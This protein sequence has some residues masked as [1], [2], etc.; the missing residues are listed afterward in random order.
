MDM[1]RVLPKDCMCKILSLTTPKDACRSSAVCLAL[2]NSADSDETWE[3]FLP[4]ELEH[5]VAQSSSTNLNSL[6][7][8]QLYLHLCDHPL[9]LAGNT[10]SFSLDKESGKKCYMIGARGLWILWSHVPKYWSYASIQ[11]SRFPEVAVLHQVWWFEVKGNFNTKLLSQ[12]TTYDVLFV[13]QFGSE[14]LGFADTSINFSLNESGIH[15]SEGQVAL[16]PPIIGVKQRK[17]GWL[18]I[19]VGEFYTED[20]EDGGSILEFKLWDFD[21]YNEKSG[22]LV[23]GFEF[24]PKSPE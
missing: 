13:F 20:E 3:A 12:R 1:A 5:L 18:E 7:K 6:A 17:D 23:E 4:A 10:M 19:K 24:R 21:D 15:K 11:E 16:Y 22:I 2:K 8:K 14:I 9:L